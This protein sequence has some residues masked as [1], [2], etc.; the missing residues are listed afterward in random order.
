MG[1]T[2]LALLIWA[3]LRASGAG[4]GDLLAAEWTW[5]LVVVAGLAVLKR[6]ESFLVAVLRAHREFQLTTELDIVESLASAVAVSLGLWL[7][8]FWG[9]LAGVGALL[10]FKIFYLHI[11]HP[12]RFQWD[13]HGPT[14]WRLMRRLADPG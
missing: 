9:L 4:L 14:A 7:A 13:W 6:Y 5:G 11:R 2:S 3:W 1:S 8:G 12:L 10:A